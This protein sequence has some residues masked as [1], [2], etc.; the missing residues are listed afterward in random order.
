MLFL[1]TEKYPDEKTYANFLKEHSGTYNA[2]TTSTHTTYLFQVG[3]EHVEKVLDMFAQ[4]FIAPL[5]TESSVAREVEAVQ[6]EHA[7][8]VVSDGWRIKRLGQ[9]TASPRHPLHKFDG[10]NAQ[11]LQCHADLREQVKK[12]WEDHYS[13]NLMTLVLVGKDSIETLEAMV[14]EKFSAIKDKQ[15]K[16]ITW[17]ENVEP[18]DKLAQRVSA[19][20]M[21]D[22]RKITL[23]WPLPSLKEHYKKHPTHYMGHIIGHEGKGSLFSYLRAQGWANSLMAGGSSQLDFSTFDITITLTPSGLQNV[24]KVIDS[25]YAFIALFKHNGI[26]QAIFDELNMMGKLGFRYMDKKEPFDWFYSLSFSVVQ[27][28]LYYAMAANHLIEEYDPELIKQL[29]DMLTPER[30]LLL[31]L[32]KDVKDPSSKAHA[33]GDSTPNIVEEHYKIEYREDPLSSD[34]VQRWK[35]ILD[36]SVEEISAQY[37]G[38]HV[39]EPN[40]FI[41]K[42]LE[43][44]PPPEGVN[45]EDPPAMIYDTPTIRLWHKQDQQ[46]SQPKGHILFSVLSASAYHSPVTV[47]KTKLFLE[48]LADDLN[49]FA[50]DTAMAGLKS[51]LVPTLDGFT[52]EISG[53]NDKIKVLLEQ[54]LKRFVTVGADFDKERFERIR[55]KVYLS[56]VNLD[57]QQSYSHAMYQ[58]SLFT[59]VPRWN[60]QQYKECVATIP[61][62][63]VASWWSDFLQHLWIDGLVTGNIAASD[64][65][66][67]AKLVQDT[68]NPSPLMPGQ[69]LTLRSVRLSPGIQ[70][71]VQFAAPNP[72]ETNS[73]TLNYYQVG[74]DNIRESSLMLL[75][76]GLISGS[77][78]ETL[79][80][81]EQLGYIVHTQPMISRYAMYYLVLVQSAKQDPAHVDSRIEAWIASVATLLEKLPEKEFKD[82][83]L[84]LA[85]AKR[86]KPTSLKKQ[87]SRYWGPIAT[88]R[89]YDFDTLEKEAKEIES[90]TIQDLIT[91]WNEHIAPTAQNRT[92]ICV[93]VWPPTQKP[94]VPEGISPTVQVVSDPFHFKASMPTYGAKP[95]A[96]PPKTPEPSNA[97]PTLLS[98]PQEELGEDDE[99]YEEHEE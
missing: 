47:A 16:E 12:F 25:V 94:H 36:S 21:A 58:F 22:T 8:D 9:V 52:L 56:Y 59:D 31:L 57:I 82:A 39:P 45:K 29:I 41:P 90:F 80:T 91:W 71:W 2:Y 46:F 13:A 74:F 17:G 1:G 11:T 35:K 6:S 60:V 18:F 93:Q 4:F 10:G 3:V 65:I 50:Y 44:L 86:V 70:H 73:A 54:I 43:I 77:A 30:S 32:A 64:A 48:Y 19:V 37:K 40:P 88:T 81:Q 51:G 62:E 95:M 68:L 63:Q 99:E 69:W 79:R 53:Y 24:D 84:A 33:L 27:Y 85:T 89:D 67:V 15:L 76:D 61:M 49:E 92:K 78:F 83:Q 72:V 20:P 5:F 96:I 14:R 34:Q 23:R 28:P 87:T 7:K 55:T 66:E 26:S 97:V 98:L 38:M 42:S 75:L